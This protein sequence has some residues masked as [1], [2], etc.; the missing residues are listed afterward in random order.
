MELDLLGLAGLA[1]TSAIVLFVVGLVIASLF[2]WFGVKIAGVDKRKRTLGNAVMAVFLMLVLSFIL[3]FV[4]GTLGSLLGILG[5]IAIIK[6][7]YTTS[8]VKAL[9]AWVFMVVA[10]FIVALVFG[11][12]ILG[13]AFL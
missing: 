10:I 4:G 9:I 7:I 6:Y 13:L 12:G 1:L 2:V 5:S 3:G 8:W 11:V